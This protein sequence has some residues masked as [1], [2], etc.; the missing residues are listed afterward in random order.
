[1][2]RKALDQPMTYSFPL[3]ENL[4]MN[5]STKP[6]KN[7]YFPAERDQGVSNCKNFLQGVSYLPSLCTE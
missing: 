2:G 1:M 7:W 4:E 6:P 3:R 5:G